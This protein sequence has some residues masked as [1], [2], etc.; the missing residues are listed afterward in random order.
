M[1]ARR[2]MLRSLTLATTAGVL[3]IRPTPAATAEPPPETTALRLG[4]F[5][6]GV[7][8][9]PQ[10]IAEEFLQGEGFTQVQYVKQAGRRHEQGAGLRRHLDHGGQP[11]TAPRPDRH[12]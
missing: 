4:Q 7:C 11:R 8:I 10:Y 3:G 9:A 6:G 5:A 1:N 12:R 2:D